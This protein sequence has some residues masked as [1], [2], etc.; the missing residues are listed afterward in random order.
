M[1]YIRPQGYSRFFVFV[2]FLLERVC[3]RRDMFNKRITR[4]VLAVYGESSVCVCVCV[5]RMG[6]FGVLE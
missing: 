5:C 3:A 2:K 6:V 1:D 4:V